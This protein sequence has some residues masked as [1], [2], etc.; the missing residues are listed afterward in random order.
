MGIGIATAKFTTRCVWIPGTVPEST[1]P[2]YPVSCRAAPSREN[3]MDPR[4]VCWHNWN[5][6]KAEKRK[7]KSL[8]GKGAE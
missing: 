5:R 2:L 8:Q 6:G 3:K 4:I 7:Q 1:P